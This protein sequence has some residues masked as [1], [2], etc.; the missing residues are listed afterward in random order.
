MHLTTSLYRSG[1]NSLAITRS[2]LNPSGTKSMR[3]QWVCR[4]WLLL[5]GSISS[6][7]K[8]GLSGLNF[9]PLWAVKQYDQ[10]RSNHGDY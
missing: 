2:W 1:R 8:M 3:T 6:I 7:K 5:I 10:S 9:L 4:G